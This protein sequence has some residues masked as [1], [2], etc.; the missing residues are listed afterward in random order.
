MKYKGWIYCIRNKINNKKY[1]GQTSDKRGYN[2][3]I[4]KHKGQLINNKHYSKNLQED[5]NKYGMDNFEFIILDEFTFTNKELLKKVLLDMEK[6][7]INLWDTENDKKGY[8]IIFGGKNKK[9]IVESC[10]C[11]TGQFGPWEKRE[12]PNR[13]YATSEYNYKNLRTVN[14][15]L[16]RSRS[17]DNINGDEGGE[18]WGG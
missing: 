1:I 9:F 18:R 15:W 16:R 8:N 2:H 12:L 13:N 5:F 11:V 4:S 7:Y 10:L 17:R 14:T 6:F 3:R